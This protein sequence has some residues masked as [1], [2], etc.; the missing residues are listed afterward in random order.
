[1][2]WFTLEP[3]G[4]RL[5]LRVTPN[6][7]NNLISS[8][9]ERADGTCALGL[10]VTAPPDKGRANQAVIALMAQALGLPKSALAITSGHTARSKTLTITA[11]DAGLHRALEA[12]GKMP[13]A[14]K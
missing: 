8:V 7:S 1:M 4:A 10:K 6:A 14:P 9:S 3:F 5:F 12:L 2:F 11:P 13:I